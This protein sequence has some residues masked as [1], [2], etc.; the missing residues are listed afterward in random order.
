MTI[1]WHTMHTLV[2]RRVILK[3]REARADAAWRVRRVGRR[4]G[5]L[6]FHLGTDHIHTVVTCPKSDLPAFAQA[7]ECSLT[8]GCNLDVGFARYHAKPVSDQGHLERLFGYVL[9]Q[10]AHHGTSL[11]LVHMGSNGPD[12]AGLRL[13]GA[14]E[15]RLMAQ[16]APRVRP[17]ELQRILLRGR[18]LVELDQLGAAPHGLEGERL[19]ALLLQSGASALGRADLDGQSRPVLRVRRSLFEIVANSPLGKTVDLARMFGDPRRR[20]R[21][22][23]RPVDPTISASVRK[24]IEFHCAMAGP[25]GTPR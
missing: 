4:F 21:L 18:P 5:L 7:V 23:A 19:E 24:L 3:T 6:V 9:R 25:A 22:V 2:D 1:A 8:R 20:R 10:E 16:T 15:R 17:D 14:H 12:L 11:D 13:A